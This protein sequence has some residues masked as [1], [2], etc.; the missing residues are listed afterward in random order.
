MEPDKQNGISPALAALLTA[1][2]T[3]LAPMVIDWLLKL[4]NEK[5][6]ESIGNFITKL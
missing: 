4:I 5:H 6:P 3:A 1:I 2:I